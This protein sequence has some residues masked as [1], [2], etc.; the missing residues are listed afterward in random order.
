MRALVLCSL[1]TFG[2][3]LAAGAEKYSGPRPPKAD[4][5]YL[6]HADNL[7]ATETA[8]AK[9]ETKKD[10]QVALI[11]GVASSA[12]TPLSEPIFIFRSDKIPADKMAAYKLEVKDG[13][14]QVVVGAKK[15][16]N[17]SRSIHL[18]VTRLDAN[19]YRIEVDEPLEPGEYTLSPDG[20]NDTFSFAVY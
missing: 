20:S 16:K 14:R 15:Q 6:L 17:V 10:T 2:S 4:L 13:K 5:P 1:L 18:M 19:L 7:L 12:K 11:D 3:V 9:D 8:V